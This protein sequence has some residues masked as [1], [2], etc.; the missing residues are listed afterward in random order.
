M[1]TPHMHSIRKFFVQSY[2]RSSHV[3]NLCSPPPAH[4]EETS[5]LH[6]TLQK[7]EFR[8]VEKFLTLKA[9]TPTG[10]Y[11]S[12]SSVVMSRFCGWDFICLVIK[13]RF[14]PDNLQVFCY[15]V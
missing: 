2:V 12:Q 15:N 10:K 9:G 11:Y 14:E 6:M 8:L 1:R 4:V 5:Y 3:F 7:D 13:T